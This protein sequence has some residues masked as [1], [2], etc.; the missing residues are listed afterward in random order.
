MKNILFPN[1]FWTHF[2]IGIFCANFRPPDL[3]HTCYTLSGL[4]VAQHCEVGMNPLVIGSSDN[5]LL[6]THPMFNIPPKA[7]W[8][9]LV[10]FKDNTWDMYDGFA[11]ARAPEEKKPMDDEDDGT[12]CGGRDERSLSVNRGGS[13]STTTD[14]DC[15]G[16][17]SSGGGKDKDTDSVITDDGISVST[18][19]TSN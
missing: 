1:S 15:S 7:V 8:K 4:S 9:S 17:E 11:D 2:K 14:D 10:H 6:P 12:D 3:Y 13:M 19:A 16:I 5:E 18:S